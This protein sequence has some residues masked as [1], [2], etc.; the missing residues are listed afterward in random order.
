[1]SHFLKTKGGKQAI[2]IVFLVISLV[3]PALLGVA[4]GASALPQVVGGV[5]APT[6]TSTV[7]VTTTGSLCSGVLIGAHHVLTAGHCVCASPC[8]MI[9]GFGLNMRQPDAPPI[10]VTQVTRP[11]GAE[12]LPPGQVYPG[13]DLALLRLDN[14]QIPTGL[15]PARL[16]SAAALIQLSPKTL[17]VVGYGLTEANRFG[18]RMEADVP[19]A[20]VAC[21]QS[22]TADSGCLEFEEFILSSAFPRG[23]PN[24]KPVDTC[25]G[26]SGGPVFL[27]GGAEPLLVG[28]T[29]RA[30]QLATLISSPACGSGGIYEII[31]TIQKMQ[32]LRQSVPDLR[33]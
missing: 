20:S 24:L 15:K 12:T 21:T 6:Q 27:L 31:G 7:F 32:W 18:Q 4:F 5:P 13:E 19:D 23:G 30:V 17:H 1:M 29:S 10:R 8:V 25:N 11:P 9:V 26:D 22:W 3:G 14:L 33:T 16:L 28:V 2:S